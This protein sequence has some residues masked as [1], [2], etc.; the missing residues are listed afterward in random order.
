MLVRMCNAKGTHDKC[1]QRNFFISVLLKSPLTLVLADACS[2]IVRKIHALVLLY[3]QI[4]M[5][6]I[7]F[8]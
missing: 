5:N 3:R 2:N 7:V 4:C 6:F 8:I 1:V